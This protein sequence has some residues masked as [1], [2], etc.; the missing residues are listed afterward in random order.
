MEFDVENVHGGELQVGDEVL[1]QAVVTE[2]K[3]VGG[4]S[5]N[6]H[7]YLKLNE[8][9]FNLGDYYIWTWGWAMADETLEILRLRTPP[10]PKTI[11][12]RLTES[13]AY[14]IQQLR[15]LNNDSIL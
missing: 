11:P 6:H 14:V 9:L 1:L 8:R 2:L 12:M 10:T 15:E 7:V 5:G 3:A 13:E 4:R